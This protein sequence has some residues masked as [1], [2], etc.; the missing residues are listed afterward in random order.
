MEISYILLGVGT[1]AFL[2]Y[3]FSKIFEKI[4]IPDVVFLMAIGLVLGPIT[5][6][7]DAESFGILGEVFAMLTLLVVLFE[8]GLH[9]KI[10]KLFT[11][12]PRA[13]IIMLATLIST[14]AVIIGF[15]YLIFDFSLVESFIVGTLLGSVSAGISIPL[16][17]KIPVSDKTKSLITF[18]A[19]INDVITVS[20]IFAIIDFTQKNFFNIRSFSA[21]IGFDFIIALLVGGLTAFVWSQIIYR[22]RDIQNNIFMTPALVLI[23]FGITEILGASGVFAALAFGIA[24]GNLQYI[25]KKDLPFIPR[26]Q[27]FALTKQEKKM[28]AGFVFLLKTYFF[29]YIGLS[30]GIED[31]TVLTWALI[32]TIILFLLRLFIVQLFIPD[33]TS[34]FDKKVLA[35][36]LPKGLV[37]AALITLVDNPMAQNFTFGVIL[38]SIVITSILIS[39]IPSK[40]KKQDN[41][42]DNNDNNIK[43]N[44][45][46][47][48]QSK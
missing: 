37:G 21:N 14:I 10:K 9:I 18:E 30:I 22:I 5:G 3:F 29:V 43:Q 46:E 13:F 33:K 31:L 15:G 1:L 24:L 27:E 23:V 8:A 32:A 39:I 4:N 2:A 40:I 41:D 28:F 11:T 38:W 48:S 7:V 17:K 47:T 42:N 12:I 16:L 19:D 34:S 6:I 35:R 44:D 26:F 45:N 20:I 36:L 25:K